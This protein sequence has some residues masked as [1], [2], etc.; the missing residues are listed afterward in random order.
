MSDGMLEI[1]TIRRHDGQ[2]Y[3]MYRVGTRDWVDLTHFDQTEAIEQPDGTFAEHSAI[4]RLGV[5]LDAGANILDMHASM[6]DNLVMDTPHDQTRSDQIATQARRAAKA[7]RA[8][9]KGET[10]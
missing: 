10:P 4:A 9:S 3:R 6:L 1:R 2:T 7:F 8:A 5:T